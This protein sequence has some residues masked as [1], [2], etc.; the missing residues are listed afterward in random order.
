MLAILPKEFEAFWALQGALGPR[1]GQ[2]GPPDGAHMWRK[3]PSGPSDFVF[4]LPKRNLA[5]PTA[6][7]PTYEC[8]GVVRFAPRGVQGRPGGLKNFQIIKGICDL[9]G[10][11]D[12]RGHL[13][14]LA[15]I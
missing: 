2:I 4:F 10:F 5:A 12:L 15:C 3:W 7:L 11:R 13:G 6:I 8:L 14:P 1:G 9:G